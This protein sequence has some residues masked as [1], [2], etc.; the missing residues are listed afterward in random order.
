MKK[1][2][3]A[4]AMMTGLAATAAQAQVAVKHI[5]PNE[6]S[7][8]ATGVWAGDTLYLSGQ[9]ADP[10]TPADVA[11]GTPAV[12]GDT[13]TQSLSIFNK[14]QKLL[15]EQGLDMKDVVKMTVFLAGDP[16]NGGK[17]DFPGLQASYTQFFGTKD[18]PNKPARSAMQVAALV[19]PTA[20]VEIEVIAV[21]GK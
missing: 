1:M 9:L 12:Y 11:K 21:K 4:A 18:Q 17:L 5:Q 19:A 13:K 10:V 7:P 2:M 6:K 15:K 16:A 3:L 14:I 20:L 8:I